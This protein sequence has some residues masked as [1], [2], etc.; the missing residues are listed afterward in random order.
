MKGRGRI[1]EIWAQELHAIAVPL[2]KWYLE[3][4][5]RH[6][7]PLQTALTDYGGTVY[8]TYPQHRL[9]SLVEQQHLEDRPWIS[10]C[11]L[12]GLTIFTDAGKQS[13]RAACT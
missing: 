2:A 6:S 7:V 8:N 4:G 12:I 10:E 1:L 5:I 11:P 13:K 3:W 9:L